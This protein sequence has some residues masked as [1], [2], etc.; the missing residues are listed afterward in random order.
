MKVFN[1]TDVETRPL[2]QQGLR[3]VPIKVGETVIPPGESRV[4]RGTARERSEV[5]AFVRKGAAAVEQLPPWYAHRRGLLVSGASHPKESAVPASTPEP[6][7]PSE[8]SEL[9][10]AA[11]S[12]KMKTRGGRKF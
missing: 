8:S 2:K 4:L 10:E 12:S 5:S 3:N 7:E 1:I 11:S 6:S 9:S